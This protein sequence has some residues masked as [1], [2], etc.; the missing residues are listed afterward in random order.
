MIPEK[1]KSLNSKSNALFSKKSTAMARGREQLQELLYASSFL[2]REVQRIGIYVTLQYLTC[3][4][5]RLRVRVVFIL[6]SCGYESQA[7]LVAAH[8]YIW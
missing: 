3:P 7:P 2:N 4:S 6:E 8:H 5:W 1:V